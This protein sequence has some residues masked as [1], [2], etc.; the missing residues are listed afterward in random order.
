M[1]LPT[2]RSILQAAAAGREAVLDLVLP[3][4]C[5]LCNQPVAKTGDF[6]SLCE[7]SLTLSEPMMQAA[8][9]RCGVPRPQVAGQPPAPEDDDQSDSTTSTHDSLPD[10][11]HCRDIA[12]E[13]EGVATLWSYQDRVCEAVV[14]AKYGSQSP[15]AAA[16]GRRLGTRVETIFAGDLPDFVTF[17]PSHVSRQFSRGGNGNQ[18]IAGAVAESID[19]PHGGLLKTTRRIK[20]QA[21]LDDA[22]RIENVRGAFSLKKSYA[23]IRSPEIAKRHVLVV[24][25]VLTTGATANEVA[26]I[27]RVGDARRVSLAVIARAIRSQ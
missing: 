1:P 27:L 8:C 11:V 21:W 26:R 12:F 15:L 23:L 16:L 10:C 20:K 19:R 13:F 4:T 24:D 14:A 22:G 9:I 7:L 17:V 2:S 18:V 6:C 5:P 3:P 25:D